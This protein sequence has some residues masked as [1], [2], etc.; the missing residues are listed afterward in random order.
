MAKVNR[1]SRTVKKKTTSTT[2][3]LYNYILSPLSAIPVSAVLLLR[4]YYQFSHR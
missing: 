3:L 4:Y 1:K 2:T